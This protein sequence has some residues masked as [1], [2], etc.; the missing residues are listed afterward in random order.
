MDTTKNDNKIFKQ[1]M[2]YMGAKRDEI[3]LEC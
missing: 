3:L 1:I 2:P